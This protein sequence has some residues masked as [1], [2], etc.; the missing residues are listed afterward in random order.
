MAGAAN[1]RLSSGARHVEAG[2]LGQREL[3]ARIEDRRFSTADNDADTVGDAEA[4]ML[5]DPSARLGEDGRYASYA[6]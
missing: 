1:A 6:K 2:M 5:I 3:F 4:A